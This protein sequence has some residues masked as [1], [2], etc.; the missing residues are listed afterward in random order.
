MTPD[1]VPPANL[2]SYRASLNA[3]LRNVAKA[4]GVSPVF[5]RKQYVFTKFLNR[6][7]TQAAEGWVLL[8]GNALLI[9]TGEADSPRT[10]TLLVKANFPHHSL[11]N[12][13]CKPTAGLRTMA[14]IGS[15]TLKVSNRA[16]T[17]ISMATEHMRSR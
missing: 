15:S 5:V 9:R 4:R 13:N 2:G 12:R 17:R 1:P 16:T 7:F 11:F 3:R 10:S 14:I 6:V 8:G